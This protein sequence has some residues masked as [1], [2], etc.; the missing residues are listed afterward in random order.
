MIDFAGNTTY[1]G[2]AMITGIDTT[3]PTATG[4]YSTTLPTNQDV[5]VTLT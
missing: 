5:T 2:S 1:S 3:K 4:S